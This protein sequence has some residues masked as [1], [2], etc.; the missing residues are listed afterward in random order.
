MKLQNIRNGHYQS[1]HPPRVTPDPTSPTKNVFLT[2]PIENNASPTQNNAPYSPGPPP[3]PPKK[4]PPTLP[5]Q[6]NPPRNPTYPK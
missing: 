5:T 4:T 1:V 3:P 6:N 2:P